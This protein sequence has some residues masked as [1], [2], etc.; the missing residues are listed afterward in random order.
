MKVIHQKET[1][2]GKHV[3]MHSGYFTAVYFG[4]L[5]T[6]GTSNITDVLLFI[7][8]DRVELGMC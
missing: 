7:C 4:W 5:M 3:W 1:W 2:A 8:I 6:Y